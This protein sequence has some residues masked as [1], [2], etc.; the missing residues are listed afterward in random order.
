MRAPREIHIRKAPFPGLVSRLGLQPSLS[1]SN[2]HA[3]MRSCLMLLDSATLLV[4]T[5]VGYARASTGRHQGRHQ[6][7]QGQRDA[8][9]KVRRPGGSLPTPC[10]GPARI[11]PA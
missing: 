5:M 1:A 11:N 7:R 10:P 6:G 9:A 2:G 4:M 8:L 3:R